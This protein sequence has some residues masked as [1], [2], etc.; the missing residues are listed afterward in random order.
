MARI[1]F[2]ILKDAISDGLGLPRDPIQNDI[3]NEALAR[4][5]KC[6]KTIFDSFQWDT[7]KVDSFLT[8][9]A[10]YVNSFTNNIITFETNIDIILAVRPVEDTTIDDNPA[11]W[12]QDEVDAAIRGEQV[13]SGRFTYLTDDT[14]NRRRIRVYADDNVDTY[15][16]LARKRFVPA[17]VDPAYSA[18][19]PSATPTDYRVLTWLIDHADAA[20]VSYIS[21]EFRAWDG[22]KKQN[23]WKALLASAVHKVEELQ[24]TEHVVYPMDGMFSDLDD[25]QIGYGAL[26]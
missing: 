10:T 2:D 19:D 16:I 12:P 7:T 18:L 25:G 26:Y 17:I 22:Q 24:A 20:L 3:L 9:N 4:Y 21:D 13:S 5:E 23:D 6:G 8:S 1:V 14:S 15:R 11:L